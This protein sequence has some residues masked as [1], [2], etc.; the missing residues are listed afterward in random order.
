MVGDAKRWN[1]PIPDVRNMRTW[2]RCKK[3]DGS[4]LVEREENI[5][6]QARKAARERCDPI[7]GIAG[8]G[9]GG[10]ALALAL[11]QRGLRVIV[12]ERDASF[13]ARAQGYG[14]TMQQA[15][16]AL[17]ALGIPFNL[18]SISSS[19]HYSFTPDGEVIGCYGRR[20][21]NNGNG[22]AALELDS[23]LRCGKEEEK[24]KKKR[25][26]SHSNSIEKKKS[27]SKNQNRH[28][29][30]QRL[31]Q[32]LF[33]SLLPDTVKWGHR[34]I[35]YTENIGKGVDIDIDVGCK[36][37]NQKRIHVDILVGADGIFSK[38]REVKLND[39]RETL[40]Y[41]GVM[42]ILGIAKCDFP[43][44]D[45]TVCQTLDGATR[46]YTMPFTRKSDSGEA[47]CPDSTDTSVAAVGEGTT[48][49]QLSFPCSIEEAKKIA[50]TPE[51]LRGEALR[52]CREWHAPIPDL[53]EN[54]N[55]RHVTGYP[56]FD[57]PLLATSKLRNVEN[58]ASHVTLLGDAAHPM[59]PFK[60]QGAN[61][62]LLDAVS[63][64]RHIYK[65]SISSNA[66]K[67]NSEK[68][69]S[70]KSM[71][72]QRNEN[73]V[74]IK[75]E[76]R[77][78]MKKKLELESKFPPSKPTLLSVEAALAQFEKEMLDRSAVKQVLQELS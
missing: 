27:S 28:I 46:L 17:R 44:Y 77:K 35:G 65:S 67:W 30:R 25:P 74:E 11:Q 15:G 72:F 43:G 37:K 61:Q 19:A 71:D 54:T 12:F 50:S 4:G 58:E 10:I 47:G 73:A 39:G 32:L 14:L 49:W 56:A 38:V 3:C 75:G 48:M 62:A 70:E 64:A 41:L 52:R 23:L 53:L 8:G 40:R 45:Q 2:N 20:L 34:I 59:S 69:G 9:I 21:R 76:M 55:F 29:P 5:M 13:N 1:T 68:L 63:L 18:E 7:I 66:R 16:T 60:G 22:S 51:S 57:R 36:G 33:E 26:R 31:R 42:V 24:K 6:Y 78:T